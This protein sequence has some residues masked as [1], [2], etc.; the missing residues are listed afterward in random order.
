MKILMSKNMPKKQDKQ[1]AALAVGLSVM[2]TT[3]AMFA[4]H[5]WDGP[6]TLVGFFGL[7]GAIVVILTYLLKL[8]RI[9]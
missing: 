1:R 9:P 5:L 4:F 6:R 3:W 2:L 8:L 7:A